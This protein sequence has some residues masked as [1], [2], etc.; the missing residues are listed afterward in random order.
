[1]SDSID[2]QEWKE[3][4]NKAFAAKQY[5]DAIQH[6]T[7]AIL[8]DKSNHVYYSNRSACHA[9]LKQWAE[10]ARDA[11]EC[12]RLDPSFVKGYYRLA[13]ALKELADYETATH[14]LRQGLA[15][16]KNDASSMEPLQKLLRQVEQLQRSLNAEKE[17]NDTATLPQRHSAGSSTLSAAAAKLD[18]ASSRELY[19][20][21]VQATQSS[22][23]LS[24]VENQLLRL[25]RDKRLAQVT[26]E[27]ISQLPAETA[28]F[29]SVGKIFLK[30]SQ[31][32]VTEYLDEKVSTTTKQQH[33]LTQKK[34]YLERRLKS[35]QQ[36]MKDILSPA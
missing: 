12:I 36:N 22:R 11:K 3:L 18:E 25:E 15:A 31:D 33:D 35:Q 10:A 17:E 20:L 14:A 26:K 24:V 9:G 13:L 6:Y 16:A 27:E 5:N 2:P 28:C 23:D 30:S 34:D 1:M 8:Y 4:G 29:R 32:R 21:E 7:K 19:D